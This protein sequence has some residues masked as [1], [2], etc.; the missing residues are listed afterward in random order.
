MVTAKVGPK[1]PELSR[2]PKR[3]EMRPKLAPRG[4]KW[5]RQALDGPKYAQKGRKYPK[6]DPRKAQ[7]GSEMYKFSSGR[8]ERHV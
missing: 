6:I 4:P 1:T 3:P 2:K 5:A 7:K 8:S